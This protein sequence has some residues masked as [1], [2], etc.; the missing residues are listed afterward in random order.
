MMETAWGQLI[1]VRLN[2]KY[3]MIHPHF[4]GIG[5]AI[6]SI[7]GMTVSYYAIFFPWS[8][9]YLFDSF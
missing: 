5:A 2:H 4:W 3:G 9:S 6:A 7:A 1:R 8:L